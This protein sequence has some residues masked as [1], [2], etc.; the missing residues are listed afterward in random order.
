MNLFITVFKCIFFVIF[1]NR[2][3]F[4]VLNVQSSII[5]LYSN[6]WII[7]VL[8]KLIFS[9]IFVDDK[10]LSTVHL[11]WSSTNLWLYCTVVGSNFFD[12]RELYSTV[13]CN[14]IRAPISVS[15]YF[16]EYKYLLV[17][18]YLII[19][20]YSRQKWLQCWYNNDKYFAYQIT[21][22]LSYL[23]QTFLS[24][25]YCTHTGKNTDNYSDESD[26]VQSMIYCTV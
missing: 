19:L 17:Y 3:Q 24:S 9:F 25:T 15:K 8:Y 7:L 20:I 12:L 5:Q 21:I 14:I 11:Q 26:D 6:M 23:E 13:Y 10:D 22:K 4:H 16:S 1:T 18:M 2:L